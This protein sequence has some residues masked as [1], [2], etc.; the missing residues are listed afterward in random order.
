FH[1]TGVQTCALPI[2][3]I[4][5]MSYALIL[6]LLLKYSMNQNLPSSY[7]HAS[8]QRYAFVHAQWHEDIVLEAYKGFCAEAKKLGIST[9][10]IDRSEERRVGKECRGR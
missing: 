10:Q 2:F 9:D 6:D 1:V 4:R 5:R 8:S 7:P 3:R